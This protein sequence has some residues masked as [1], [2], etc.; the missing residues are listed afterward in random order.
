MP[1]PFHVLV[2]GVENR[3]QAWEDIQTRLHHDS[4][5]KPR[6]TVTLSRSFGCE[7]FPIA[8]RVKGAL[9]QASGEPWNIYDK[10]LL[11]AVEKDEGVSVRVMQ[12]LGLTASRFERLGLAP[13]E[14]YEQVR[15]FDSMAR[16]IVSIAGGGNAIIV[17]RGGAVLCQALKNCFHFRVDAPFEWRVESIAKRLQLPQKEAEEFV[18]AN[19]QRRDEF[20]RTMLKADPTAPLLY[21]AVF[22]NARHGVDEIS[23]AI[24]AYVQAGW[25]FK[26]AQLTP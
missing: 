21:D 20:V 10:T 22:N 5:V 23:A 25:S 3:L 9:E 7:G 16:H 12:N 13:K 8:E 19:S 2:P 6:A 11:E 17:G 14:Y 26:D 4:A 18:R 1:R 15:G 24:I